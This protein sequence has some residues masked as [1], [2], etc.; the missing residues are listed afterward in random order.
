MAKHKP[1]R[2]GDTVPLQ[3]INPASEEIDAKVYVSATGKVLGRTSAGDGPH[4][5]IDISSI[6]GG[7]GWQLTGNAGTTPGT[8]YIGTSDNTDFV[9]G[10]GGNEIIRFV[11]NA[12][13]SIVKF[14]KGK[15]VIW[16]IDN[17]DVGSGLTGGS[18]QM[19]SGPGDGA[20]DGGLLNFKG[21]D[22]GDTG[23]GGEVLFQSG[24]AGGSAGRSGNIAFYVANN[25]VGDCGD[26][27]LNGG[28]YGISA[29]G[30]GS[31]IN[32]NG[33]NTG[34]SEGGNV[35]IS[36]GNGVDTTSADGGDILLTAG[37]NGSTGGIAGHINIIA[38][39][40]FSKSG[41]DGGVVLISGGD[42][43][44]DAANIGGTVTV[45]GGTGGQNGNGGDVNIIS[46]DA[47]ISAGNSGNI[48]LTAGTTTGGTLGTV[49]TNTSFR[50]GIFTASTLPST[51][52]AGDTAF[53]T[54]ADTPVFGS[55]VVGG[56]SSE[57][58]VFFGNSI[59]NVG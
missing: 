42:A 41:A 56:G 10:V 13:S 24:S 48:N 18:I 25:D 2:I 7:S 37:Y 21:G 11:Y 6:G 8:D 51:A 33:G 40:G 5:E 49:I 19:T 3:Q 15:N 55:A 52:V 50:L 39:A 30:I 27:V 20:G 38:G 23:D 53:V 58:P 4:E 29:S 9:I 31:N 26:I 34:L 32:I 28:S 35:N 57:V 17:A 36:A 47:G 1:I 46:G 16:T 43:D 14:V 12:F 59:W 45:K 44:N 54:D 22:G